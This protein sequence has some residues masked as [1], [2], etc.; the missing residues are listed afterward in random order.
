LN[1]LCRALV[2]VGAFTACCWGQPVVNAV[3]N[4]ASYGGNIA[5]GTWVAIFGTQLAPSVATAPSVPLPTLL[6]GVSVSIGGIAAPLS[7]VSPTQVNAIVPF[8]SPVPN[9]PPV[10]VTNGFGSSVARYIQI[11]GNSPGLFTWN[12]AG[13]GR[14]LA[15]D[16]NFNPISDVGNGPIIMYADGLGPTNPPASSAYGGASAEPLNRVV[17][18]IS[19]FVGDTQATI[20]FAGL[21]PGF[22][23]IYQLNVIP[24]GPISDR[25]YIQVNGWQSN[26]TSLPILPGSNVANVTGTIS[27]LYPPTSVPV[28]T[29]ELLIAGTFG[30]DF[31]IL[32][33]ARPFSVVA[34]G[35][36]GN[37]MVNIDPIKGTW[38]AALSEPTLPAR[39][40]NFTPA[41][42]GHLEVWDLATCASNGQCAPWPGG[43][44][45]ATAMDPAAVQVMNLLPPQNNCGDGTILQGLPQCLSINGTYSTTGNLPADG[46]FS[47]GPSALSNLTNFGGFL[48][49]SEVGPPTRSTTF[50]LYVDGKLISTNDVTYGVIQP[51]R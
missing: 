42:S 18:D 31:D 21:A 3:L 22:P 16:P 23:G 8:E 28:N 38:Q 10:V 4:G 20:L 46:H 19:V 27:S 24:N 43:Q 11:G 40:G 47:I 35:E 29:S 9:Q 51:A 13:T 1:L 14:V 15:F 25:V 39:A 32:P 2:A 6:H 50:S 41:F 12:A 44:I 48:Q 49:I 45:P 37:A 17:D 33:A 7:Y 34:A 5:P 26:I 30:V 36:G